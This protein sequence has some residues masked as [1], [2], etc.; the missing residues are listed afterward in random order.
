MTIPDSKKS[1]LPLI[2]RIGS[3]GRPGMI[4]L[5]LHLAAITV[6]CFAAGFGILAL[7]GDKGPAGGDHFMFLNESAFLTPQTT[8]VQLDDAQ[9]AEIGIVF[10]TGNLQVGSGGD[11]LLT[12]TCYGQ[13]P[14]CRSFIETSASGTE[15]IVKIA[16]KTGHPVFPKRWDILVTGRVPVALDVTAGTGDINLVIGG[17]NLTSL[18]VVAGVGDGTI[19]LTGYHGGDFAGTVT[20]N[21]GDMTIRV[22]KNRNV[23]ISAGNG[24]GDVKATGFTGEDGVFSTTGYPGI[25]IEVTQGVGSVTLEAV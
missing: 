25:R 7:D 14:D 5:V 23:I 2:T 24:V 9:S 8:T 18:R 16:Q 17:L 4:R 13:N 19:D 11:G 1:P 3:I 21:I 15:K 6:I 20:Q 12:S 22:P 10:G